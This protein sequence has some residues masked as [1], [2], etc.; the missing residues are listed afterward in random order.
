[1]QHT[2][3]TVDFL[4]TREGSETAAGTELQLN[5][6]R[7]PIYFN[8]F[9]NELGN[10]F[11]PKIYAG[12]VPGLRTQA[13]VDDMD[14]DDIF[15]SFD[16]GIGGGLGFNYQVAERTWLNVDVR[17]VR[18]IINVIEEMSVLEDEAFNQYFQGSVGL[19]FGI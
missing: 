19:A 8:Y 10:P 12:V 3:I 11:R 4:F 18:G 5:Y 13:E 6:L 17:Y 1:M 7:L 9:F 2:G 15:N 16:L 14:A